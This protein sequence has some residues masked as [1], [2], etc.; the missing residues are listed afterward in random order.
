M[1]VTNHPKKPDTPPRWAGRGK[2][3]MA[4]IEGGPSSTAKMILLDGWDSSP[5]KLL[6]TCRYGPELA[7]ELA[8]RK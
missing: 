1:A 7:G 2:L 3:R 6:A 5:E 8:A 4:A